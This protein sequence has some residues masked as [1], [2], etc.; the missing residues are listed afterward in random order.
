MLPPE[1]LK[2]VF[3]DLLG[4]PKTQWKPKNLFTEWS[5]KTGRDCSEGDLLLIRMI[6]E[7]TITF[8]GPYVEL[9][10]RGEL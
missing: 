9:A 4:E 8:S 2:T 7:G 5:K 3:V 10:N 1:E 6:V